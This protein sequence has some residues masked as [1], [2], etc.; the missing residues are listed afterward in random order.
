MPSSVNGTGDHCVE[1]EPLSMAIMKAKRSS[2][3]KAAHGQGFSGKLPKA[4]PSTRGNAHDSIDTDRRTLGEEL[5]S[6]LRLLPTSAVVVIP[7]YRRRGGSISEVYGMIS[8]SFAPVSL[9]PKPYVSLN[10]KRSSKTYD[11]MLHTGAFIVLAPANAM[12]SAAFAKWGSKST[13]ISEIVDKDTGVPKE[14]SGVLWWAHC[15][16]LTDKSVEIGDHTIVV[17]KVYNVGKSDRTGREHAVIYADDQYRGLGP[18]IHPHD[19]AFYLEGRL[20]AMGMRDEEGGPYTQAARKSTKDKIIRAMKVREVIQGRISHRAGKPGTDSKPKIFTISSQGSC[21][22]EAKRAESQLGAEG[23]D[24][25]PQAHLLGNELNYYTKYAHY[26]DLEIEKA[27]KEIWWAQKSNT[28][29]FERRNEFSYWTWLQDKLDHQ[30]SGVDQKIRELRV[31]EQQTEHRSA[32]ELEQVADAAP[33]HLQP[34]F[35]SEESSSPEAQ[36]FE[37]HYH[38]ALP[39]ESQARQDDV[40]PL[41]LWGP[42]R[43]TLAVS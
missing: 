11:Q 32:L 34:S 2:V 24:E 19:D 23:A 12:L 21:Q 7:A 35:A 39:N 42:N 38:Y 1:D 18:V 41:V 27:A 25:L 26:L 15:E 33:N 17:G 22:S 16:L 31:A 30:K 37:M 14:N 29:D 43:G 6:L 4:P 9:N 36:D 40:S 13:I 8:P 10:I 28:R 3:P 20:H 5:R